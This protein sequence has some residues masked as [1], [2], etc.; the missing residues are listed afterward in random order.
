MG[1]GTGLS[2]ACL[3][4]H[5]ALKVS[6]PNYMICGLS[7][8]MTRTCFLDHGTV[9][10]LGLISCYRHVARDIDTETM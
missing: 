9:L 3:L 4:S 1:N 8:M 6:F 2:V 10:K 7:A 5:I